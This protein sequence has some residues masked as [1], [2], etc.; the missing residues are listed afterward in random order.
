M[1]YTLYDTHSKMRI[2]G[3]N[4]YTL[5]YDIYQINQATQNERK[6]TVVVGRHTIPKY[7][8]IHF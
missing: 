3:Q 4:I 1:S 5:S 8:P 7:T 2:C 6:T